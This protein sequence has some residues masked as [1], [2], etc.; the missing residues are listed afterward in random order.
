MWCL[1]REFPASV[2]MDSE[3]QMSENEAG[4]VSGSVEWRGWQWTGRCL[5]SLFTE[6]HV[7]ME[8]SDP[9]QFFLLSVFI[10]LG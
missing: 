5:L 2:T 9:C 8:E 6:A 3:L 10:I 4:A 7:D 1:K